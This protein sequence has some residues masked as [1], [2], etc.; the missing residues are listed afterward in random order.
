M[1]HVESVSMALRKVS[2]AIRPGGEYRFTCPNYLFPYEPHFDIPT[3]F[4]KRL[5]GNVLRKLILQSDR[6]ADPAL[7]WQS[8]NWITV[9]EVILVT[10]GMSDITMRFNRKMFGDALVRVTSDKEFAARRSWWVRKLAQAIV[11]LGLHRITVHLPPHIQ[12]VIDC[13]LKKRHAPSRDI[14][15]HLHGVRKVG[16]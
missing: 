13:T 7:V 6:V 9:P 3:L 15:A 14:A 4:S 16:V 2:K 8:L 1:E 12:P 10:R 5:T 11:S